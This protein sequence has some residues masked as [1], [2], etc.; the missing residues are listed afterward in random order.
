MTCI[1]HAIKWV[2]IHFT[3]RMEQSINFHLEI[4]NTFKI[5]LS[6]PNICRRNFC[7]LLYA[8]YTV[9]ND[10]ERKFKNIQIKSIHNCIRIR[11]LVINITSREGKRNVSEGRFLLNISLFLV[12][13]VRTC[14]ENNLIT[15][16]YLRLRWIF[17]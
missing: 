4:C 6:Y 11:F 14:R 13:F 8:T 16:I 1:F 9:C 17:I 12:L 15:H 5:S 7:H 10:H 3:F 2:S